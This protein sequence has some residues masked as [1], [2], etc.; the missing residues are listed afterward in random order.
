MNKVIRK[1][2]KVVMDPF[3]LRWWKTKGDSTEAL[4]VTPEE[5]EAKINESYA[6]GQ[7]KDG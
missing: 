6:P 2:F 3:A 7:L 4:N 5:F 1:D